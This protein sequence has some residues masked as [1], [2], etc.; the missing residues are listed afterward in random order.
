MKI[1]NKEFD[2]EHQGYIMG[3]LNV[4]PDSFSDGGKYTQI[5]QAL[6]HTERMLNEGADII[7]IG[8][9]STRPGHEKI[10]SGEEIERTAPVIEALKREF[11]RLFPW[12][13][14]NPRWQRREYMPE[15]I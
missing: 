1:G 2:M 8:G 3:I 10:T 13:P 11:N 7:D 5:D 9:E 6:K 14:T 15:P 12:I 4:T